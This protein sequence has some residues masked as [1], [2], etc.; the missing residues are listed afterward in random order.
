MIAHVCQPL[1]ISPP[2]IVPLAA[3]GSVWNGCGSYFFAN[4]MISASR[5][6][7]GA[8]RVRLARP[9]VLEVFHRR[10][11]LRD[12]DVSIVTLHNGP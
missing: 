6:G 1:A 4:A 10:H 2:K 12:L 8:E 5:D 3:S 11:V 7:V 9:D